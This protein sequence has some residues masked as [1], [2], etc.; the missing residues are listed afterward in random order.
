[1][2]AAELR[3]KATESRDKVG[4]LV[5]KAEKENREITEEE[6]SLVDGWKSE[7][8][9]FERRA[10]EVEYVETALAER[11]RGQGRVSDPVG[12]VETDSITPVPGQGEG[13]KRRSI[14]DFCRDIVLIQD[15]NTSREDYQGAQD[16]MQNLYKSRYRD[17]REVKTKEG[18]T[19]SATTGASGGFLLPK[20]FSAEVR[21]YAAPVAIVRPRATVIQMTAL[22]IEFPQLDASTVPTGG[23]AHF[24][25][26]LMKWGGET[27]LKG[28]TEP[29]FKQGKL[30]AHE[31]SGYCPVSRMLLMHSPI[32]LDGFLFKIFGESAARE[33]DRAFFRGNVP[34][35]PE[36]ILAHASL[37]ATAA[38]GSATAI[39]FANAT[40]VWTRIPPEMRAN[41]VWVAS[42]SAEA[43]VLQMAGVTNGVFVQN[44]IVINSNAP[45]NA[46]P[47]GVNLFNR[48]VLISSLMPALNTLGDFGC[49][50]LSQYLIG[51][52]QLM[53]MATSEHYLFR[54]NQVAF[55]LVEYVAGAPWPASALTL[56]DGTTTVSPFVAL[57]I[58]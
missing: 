21:R 44:S 10:K 33:E 9:S 5:A 50:D 2:T 14:G 55:R 36:G 26:V 54:N 16:R 8:E 29:V 11:D 22:E 12:G 20:D 51:D 48:P 43:T 37:V 47:P 17:Y 3:R 53:E 56:D 15:R 4:V 31:L 19:L 27:D 13:D 24:G 28:A 40:A 32:S 34:T 30:T 35:R 39:S 41:A 18:R 42:Q 52:P 25:G 23:S 45:I 49:Y 6:R 46:G 7:A 57:Q 1:M 38:R 58:Q